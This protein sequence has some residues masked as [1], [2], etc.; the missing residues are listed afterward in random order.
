MSL[1]LTDTT[2]YVRTLY[3]IISVAAIYRHIPELRDWMK[4]FRALS[5]T[6]K[7]V[8]KFWHIYQKIDMDGSGTIEIKEMLVHFD[9]D[10]TKF[11]KRVFQIFD[12]DGS[13]EIDLREFILALWNYC[14]L[15]KSTL[16]IFAFDLYDKDGSGIIDG[17]E[18]AQ[19]LKEVYGNAYT[20]NVYAQR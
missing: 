1:E 12:E 5:L 11:T 10:R 8:E 4:E 7:A 15:G 9:I 6:E 14:T 19:M 20:T 17:E 3:Y 18:L 13:G 2:T 16:I